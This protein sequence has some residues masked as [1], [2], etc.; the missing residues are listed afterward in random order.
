MTLGQRQA[1][2]GGIRLTE[3][4]R[5]IGA[6][7]GGV[8][9]LQGRAT[10]RSCGHPSR[11]ARPVKHTQRCRVRG[12]LKNYVTLDESLEALSLRFPLYRTGMGVFSGS[13]GLP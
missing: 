7:R 12:P 8:M 2:T 5:V 11:E 13:T 9:M 10:H 3:V 4:G 6:G 1:I